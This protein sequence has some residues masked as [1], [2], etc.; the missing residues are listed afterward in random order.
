MQQTN[1]LTIAYRIFRITT[2]ILLG[3]VIVATIWAFAKNKSRI[4][5][6]RW[7][8][9]RL[10]D[11]LNFQIDT[12]GKLPDDKLSKTMFIA[13][14]VS[15]TDIHALNSIIP[16]QFIAKSDINNWPIFGYL[17]R[18]SGTIFINRRSRKDTARIVETT[19]QH[20]IMGGNVGFFP[21]GTTT[22]G[23]CLAHFKSS[24]VQAAINA[25]APLHPVAIRYPLPNGGVNTQIAYA[26][27]TS[28]GESMMNILKQK[29]PVV[30]L[31]FLAQ[32][33]VQSEHRRALSQTAFEAISS[34]LNL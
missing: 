3:M 28:F 32:I 29:N 25:N 9:K 11:H 16:L 2:H 31:H 14:H 18:K 12:Y 22:D 30:E 13:N 4:K 17:A 26:G 10:L 15:W 20:L 5:L 34:Q 19:A 23:T 33:D 27:D 6:T 8:C 1:T 7:W 24:I 21:E